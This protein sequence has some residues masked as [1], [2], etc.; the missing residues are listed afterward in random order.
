[1]EDED[2]PTE[3]GKNKAAQELGKLGG[4]VRANSMSETRRPE[5][6][7]KAGLAKWKKK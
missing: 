5:I 1:L 6:A 3:D 7:K 2:A 4:E